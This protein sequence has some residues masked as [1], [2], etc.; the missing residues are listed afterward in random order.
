MCLGIREVR[1]H[2]ISYHSTDFVVEGKNT[3]IFSFT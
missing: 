2:G 1:F 3:S